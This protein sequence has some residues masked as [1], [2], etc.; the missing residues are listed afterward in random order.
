M[1]RIKATRFPL[2]GQAII[3]G[4]STRRTEM[5]K[6]L[7]ITA[8]KSFNRNSLLHGVVSAAAAVVRNLLTNLKSIDSGGNSG[9]L[10]D[11]LRYDIGMLDLNPDC[12]PRTA[13][14]A[15]PCQYMDHLRS[16]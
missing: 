6:L 4:T 13:R 8:R 7:T 9:G 5:T 12:Q 1:H 2:W 3:L 11:R 16:I 14:S 15:A 10:T